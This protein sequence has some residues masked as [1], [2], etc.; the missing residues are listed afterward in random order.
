LGAGGGDGEICG[1]SRDT[2]S[3]LGGGEVIIVVGPI[4]P[5]SLGFWLAWVTPSTNNIP[6]ARAAHKA[7]DRLCV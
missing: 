3:L 4:R 5:Y 1:D 6:E 2:G 7:I